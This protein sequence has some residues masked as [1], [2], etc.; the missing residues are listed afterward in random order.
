MTFEE[1]FAGMGK[2]LD[3][4]YKLSGEYW[5]ISFPILILI[6]YVVM[7]FKPRGKNE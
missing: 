5:Y 7:K 6:I 4:I 2:I 1:T 3:F